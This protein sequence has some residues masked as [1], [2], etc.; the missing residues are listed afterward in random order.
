MMTSV[1]DVFENFENFDFF[2]SVYD[3]KIGAPQ[4]K[5]QG[6]QRWKH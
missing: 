5:F 2:T 4:A 1:Y 3:A 6:F